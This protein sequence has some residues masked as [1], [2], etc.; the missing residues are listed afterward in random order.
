MVQKIHCFY[1]LLPNPSRLLLGQ[2]HFSVCIFNSS[3]FVLHTSFLWLVYTKVL[4][5]CPITVL[6]HILHHI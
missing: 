1:S 4:F 6:F 3:S 5:G 2:A